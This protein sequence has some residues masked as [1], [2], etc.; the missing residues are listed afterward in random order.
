[1]GAVCLWLACSDIP[2]ALCGACLRHGTKG[3][4]PNGAA[5][6]LRLPPLKIPLLKPLLCVR[7]VFMLSVASYVPDRT[8]MQAVGLYENPWFC[9]I[10]SIR[11][12]KQMSIL[13]YVSRQQ[14]R[15][16]EKEEGFPQGGNL[17]SPLWL[18]AKGTHR[19][20]L[21]VHKNKPAT[22]IPPP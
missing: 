7:E 17:G 2:I 5:P 19:I 18:R 10:L 16:K 14:L 11:S 20:K 1:M 12:P 13:S 21:S 6:P 4:P 9:M 3:G 8:N 15:H 22:N